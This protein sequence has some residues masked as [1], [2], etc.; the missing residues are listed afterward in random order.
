MLKLNAKH[1]YPAIGETPVTGSDVQQ[2]SAQTPR[3]HINVRAN[4]DSS[5]NAWNIWLPCKHG[6]VNNVKHT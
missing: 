1:I 3:E 5:M 6:S 4:T 2:L